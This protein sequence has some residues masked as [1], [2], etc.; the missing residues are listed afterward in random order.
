MFGEHG[1]TG[2]SAIGWMDGWMDAVQY[3]NIVHRYK[4]PKIDLERKCPV[5][6]L[7]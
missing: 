2:C 7:C 1:A 5:L 4:N 3:R 6:S